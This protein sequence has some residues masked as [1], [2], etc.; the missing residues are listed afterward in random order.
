MCRALMAVLLVLTTG[1]T[2]VVTIPNPTPLP[3]CQDTTEKVKAISQSNIAP[4]VKPT[5]IQTI[6]TVAK[7]SCQ[8]L[9]KAHSDEY[10]AEL[11]RAES[12]A[13][14][15]TTT[16]GILLNMLLGAGGLAAGIIAATK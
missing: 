5:L 2:R 9:L 15:V 6:E 8:I 14:N 12:A 7:D 16:T 10:A 3:A 11:A 1:C 13:R 4:E